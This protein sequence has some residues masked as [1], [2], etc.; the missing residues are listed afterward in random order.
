MILFLSLFLQVQLALAE[1]VLL[2]ILHQLEL[3]HLEF[4]V[5]PST[6]DS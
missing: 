2:F 3:Q 5:G 6:L 4:V 1:A